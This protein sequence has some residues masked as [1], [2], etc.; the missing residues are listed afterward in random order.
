MRVIVSLDMKFY[1]IW[2]FD[3]VGALSPRYLR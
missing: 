1:A 3:Y 2:V